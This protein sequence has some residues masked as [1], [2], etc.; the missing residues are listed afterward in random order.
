MSYFADLEPFVIRAHNQELIN[1]VSKLRL[2]KRLWDNHQ[3]RS[4]HAF[5]FIFERLMP[6]P[7]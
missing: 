7:R 3:P 1:E 5:A 6:Q 2:E 4:G